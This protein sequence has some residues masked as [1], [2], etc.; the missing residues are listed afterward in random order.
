MRIFRGRTD[1]SGRSVVW[2]QQHHDLNTLLSAIKA[3]QVSPAHSSACATWVS[4]KGLSYLS[5]LFLGLP[6]FLTALFLQVEMLQ[7]SFAFE[8]SKMLPFDTSSN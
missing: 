2:V 8:N 4:L 7:K 6:D 3:C 5:C 1:S